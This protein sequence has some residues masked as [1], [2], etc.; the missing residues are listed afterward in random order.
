MVVD[1][2]IQLL[3]AEDA[4][5]LNFARSVMIRNDKVA[6]AETI[7]KMRTRT[8]AKGGNAIFQ[9]LGPEHIFFTL[10]GRGPGAMPPEGI[11]EDWLDDRNLDLDPYPIRRNIAENG[12]VAGDFGFI[13]Q[14]E[15]ELLPLLEQRLQNEQAAAII[16]QDLTNAFLETQNELRRR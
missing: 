15:A 5:I 3:R 10:F 14:F 6:S 7:M 8:R 12:T 1:R 13:N 11:I 9:L 16:F 4:N 2:V